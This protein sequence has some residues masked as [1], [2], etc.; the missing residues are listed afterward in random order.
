MIADV[1]ILD[2]KLESI[3]VF[4]GCS[5]VNIEENHISVS[6]GGQ[7][8]INLIRTNIIIG[9][10]YIFIYGTGNKESKL[11]KYNLRIKVI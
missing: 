1:E 9:D 6:K 2:D 8:I 11:K 5:L 7:E 10:E 4:P 3:E